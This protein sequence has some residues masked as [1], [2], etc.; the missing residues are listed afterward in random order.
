MTAS[1]YWL[2][3]IRRADLTH[4]LHNFTG[5]ISGVERGSDE[6]FGLGIH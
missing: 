2:L 3:L 6:D 5:E 1:Q 4:L